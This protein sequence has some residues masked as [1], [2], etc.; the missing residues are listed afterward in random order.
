MKSRIELD[1]VD[2]GTGI[3]PVIKVNL[4]PS[5]DPRDKLLK[6]LFQSIGDNLE[7]IYTNNER[8][9]TEDGH[10]QFKST[11][12][13]RSHR[14][15]LKS[16]KQIKLSTL[17]SVISLDPEGK[18]YTFVFDSRIFESGDMITSDFSHMDRY[19]VTSKPTSH[20]DFY[21]YD[22]TLTEGQCNM[23]IGTLYGLLDTEMDE[24]E[25]A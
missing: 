7:V 18:D 12:F 2:F 6:S 25:T 8:E 19:L 5:D 11:V 13:L 21:L 23:N 14:E 15:D 3:E 22:V 4:N 17:L 1:V 10:P 9:D 24:Q 16:N 20:K